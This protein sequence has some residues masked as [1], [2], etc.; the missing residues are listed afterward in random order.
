MPSTIERE[1]IKMSEILIKYRN[2]RLPEN[3]DELLANADEQ[4]LRLLVALMMAADESGHV[5][6]DFS[7]ADTLGLESSQ[8]NASLKFWRGAGVISTARKPKTV[9][10]DEL[11]AQKAISGVTAAHREGAV[12]KNMG[13]SPYATEELAAL[14]ERRRVSAQFIDEAQRVVGKTFNSYDTGIVAG[15]V[16]QL[17]FEE[18]AVLHILSYVTR[19]GKKGIRYSEKLAMSFY[20]DGITTAH[21]VSE[22]IARIEHSNEAVHKIKQLFGMGSREL[23]KTERALFDKWTQKFGYDIDVIRIAY[24]ITVDTIQKPVPKYAGT[25]LERWYTEGLRTADEVIAYEQ[26]QKQS[27]QDDHEKSYDLDDFFEAALQRSLEELK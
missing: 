2:G 17:G 1:G 7:I 13:V 10:A 12:E 8:T 16:D 19:I 27:K 20:D 22:R 18:E 24:D 5:R 6:E 9:N 14:F 26:A 3:L 11:T 4:D 23:S 25:I 21:E 15:L